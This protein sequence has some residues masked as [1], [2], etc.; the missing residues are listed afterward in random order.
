MKIGDKAIWIPVNFALRMV[1]KEH[2]HYGKVV[3]IIEDI[4]RLGRYRIS[5]DD[6]PNCNSRD[7]VNRF[8]ADE[9]ELL[10]IKNFAKN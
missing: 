7:K 8:M 3:T 2:P 9:V 6:F 5:V 1:E 10:E 4:D